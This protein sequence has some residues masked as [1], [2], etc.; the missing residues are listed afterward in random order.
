MEKNILYWNNLAVKAKKDAESFTELYQHFFPRVYKFIYSKIS[1]AEFADEI[2]S[3]TFLKV[4]EHLEKYNP[5]RAAFST[6]L[7]QI[8]L[9]E[10]RYFFRKN[11]FPLEYQG[12]VDE[13]FEIPASEFEQPEQKFLAGET[14]IKIQSALEKLSERER[15]I[16]EMTYFLDYPPRKIAEILDLTPNHVSVLLKRAK[17]NLKKFLENV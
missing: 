10:L 4:Y 6:W 3:E 15:K 9:N 16:L 8:A 1:N 7:Y 13:N 2:I 11:K 17:N 14:K 12:E 5:E